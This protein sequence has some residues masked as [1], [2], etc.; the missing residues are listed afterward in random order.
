MPRRIDSLP[1]D[2]G[3]T[4]SLA[5]PF[6]RR[7]TLS[8][9]I[10]FTVLIPE[11]R[12]QAATDW[13]EFRGPSGQGLSEAR[14]VP[15]HW[16]AT[17]NIAWKIPIA[18]EGWS[19]TVLA[20][21][22]IYLTTATSSP[23]GG[24]ELRALALDPKDG[25][26]VWNQIVFEEPGT[27]GSMHSKNSKASPTPL[28]FQD[29]LVVHFGHL[30][31]ACLDSSG[32]VLWRQTSLKY[33]P[34]HGNGGSPIH[35]GDGIFFSCD[36][37]EKPFAVLLD[38]KSGDIRWRRDR[39]TDAA[40]KFSF[41]TALLITNGT[42]R[43]IISPASGAVLAY[44]PPTGHELW[45]VTYGNGYSVVP[46]PVFANG[47]LFIGTGYD[48]ASLL[49]I[50]P[51]GDGDLTATHIAWQTNRGAPNTP[52]VLVDQGRIYFVS[53]GGVATC[54]EAATGK[55]LWNERLPGDYSASLVGAE[56]RVYFINEAGLCTV[57]KAGPTF[58]I[59]AKNDLGERTL[60]SP[61]VA[62]GAL[63]LRTKEHLY[64]IGADKP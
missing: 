34:V 13:P 28:V 6:L 3:G 41:S 17:T 14:Q 52:S 50:R 61:A 33:S 38:A 23:Q 56:G 32:K 31:T 63:F 15:T 26:T 8:V 24:L 44:D 25:H 22:R 9:L 37:A 59:V 7:M 47:L 39:E 18:G 49:A 46:R 54:A 45:R 30:G 36:G 55:V 35:A 51:G 64:R 58:E 2:R 42:R 12:A 40:K 62:D 5:M 60:A 11:R 48:R 19:S 53:D 20:H 29:Q 4:Y 43:E 57:V 27:G 1:V 16:T 10:G 21:G